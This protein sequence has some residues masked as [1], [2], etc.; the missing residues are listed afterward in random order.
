MFMALSFDP[1]LTLLCHSIIIIGI[2]F[3][4]FDLFKPRIWHF[5]Y[6]F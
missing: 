4:G 6:V 1:L 3:G 2:L 5:I